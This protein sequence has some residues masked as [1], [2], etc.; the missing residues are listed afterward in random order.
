ME[1]FPTGGS[2]MAFGLLTLLRVTPRRFATGTRHRGCHRCLWPTCR[3]WA[4]SCPTNLCRRP[5]L[6][7]GT[8]YRQFHRSLQGGS[9]AVNSWHYT[10]Y[11]PS[12][13]W[14]RARPTGQQQRREPRNAFWTSTHG[15][16]ALHCM[17]VAWVQ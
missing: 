17:W 9:S 3:H 11:S 7:L 8:I 10:S 2:S 12:A 15:C 14:M 1:A 13:W 16:N 4:R 5:P 6:R